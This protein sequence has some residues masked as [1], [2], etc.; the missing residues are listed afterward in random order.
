ME[1]TLHQLQE[2]MSVNGGLETIKEVVETLKKKGWIFY[3]NS[4]SGL[5]EF[6]PIQLYLYEF[7]S[8]SSEINAFPIAKS[9]FGSKRS[10]S[11][12]KLINEGFEIY[13]GE[14]LTDHFSV[15]EYLNCIPYVGE[16]YVWFYRTQRD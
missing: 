9:L 15:E 6:H 2:Q 8:P 10:K 13:Y 3:E 16:E 7:P 5:N 4:L 1:L 14:P 11:I 12:R